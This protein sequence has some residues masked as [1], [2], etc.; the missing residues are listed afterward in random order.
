MLFRGPHVQVLVTHGDFD[1]KQWRVFAQGEYDQSL[2]FSY[3]KWI[4]YQ[5][6]KHSDLRLTIFH[7]SCIDINIMHV[8]QPFNKSIRETINFYLSQKEKTLTTNLAGV[9]DHFDINENEEFDASSQANG[10]LPIHS[11]NIHLKRVKKGTK[12]S[13]LF[14]QL[15]LKK[16]EVDLF[17][18]LD[19]VEEVWEDLNVRDVFLMSGDTLDEHVSCGVVRVVF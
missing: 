12:N 8:S 6:L 4:L 19:D 18:K 14:Q 10:L 16:S 7:R 13:E 2:Q 5:V 9:S 17:L 11:N 1:V 15:Q 3:K